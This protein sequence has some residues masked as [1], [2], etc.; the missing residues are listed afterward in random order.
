MVAG[1]C[2]GFMFCLHVSSFFEVRARSC[3]RSLVRA[4]SAGLGGCGSY[5]RGSRPSEF[6]GTRASSGGGPIPHGTRD[7]RSYYVATAWRTETAAVS[8]VLCGFGWPG[9][10][11]RRGKQFT[12]QRVPRRRGRHRACRR[13]ERFLETRGDVTVCRSGKGTAKQ[14]LRCSVFP[15]SSK[16]A[17]DNVAVLLKWRY[18]VAFGAFPS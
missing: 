13:C 12:G 1:Q 4:H 8:C 17:F 5:G 10:S 14:D 2:T 18:G 11:Q 7:V 6:C 3:A 15:F 9:L 16:F